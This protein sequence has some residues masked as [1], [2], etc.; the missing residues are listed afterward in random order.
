MGFPAVGIRHGSTTVQVP[1]GVV[2]YQSK[3]CSHN[4]AKS[5]TKGQSYNQHFYFPIS[6]QKYPKG[7]KRVI[8]EMV[9]RYCISG[10]FQV[11]YNVL[12]AETRASA[13]S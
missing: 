12:E 6:I 11:V 13:F 9:V 1:K 2:V 10:W 5:G 7:R 3:I 4:I 8:R